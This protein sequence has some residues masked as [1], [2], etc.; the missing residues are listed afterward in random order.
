MYFLL[1]TQ[2]LYMDKR[3]YYILVERNRYLIHKMSNRSNEN[4]LQAS[5]E[6]KLEWKHLL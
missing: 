5:Q 4:M 2:L 3:F 6:W 1:Q